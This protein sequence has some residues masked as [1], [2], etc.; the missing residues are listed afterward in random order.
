M[1]QSQLLRPAGALIA[2]AWIAASAVAQGPVYRE[3]WGYLHLEHRRLELLAEL[4]GA[5]AAAQ[6]HAAALLVQPDDGV[7]FT[8]VTKALAAVR[9]VEAD[10]A[11][12]LRAA[13]GVYL[14]P[15]VCDP[16][17]RTEACRD[18]N[19]TVFLP[20]MVP[21]P[22][23]MVFELQAVDAGGKVVFRQRLDRE[24]AVADL[25]MARPTAKVPG[26]ELADGAYEL[27]VRALF[28]GAAPRP[29][30]P[31]LRWTF[32][33]LRGYQARAEAALSAA[34]AATGLGAADA[35]LLLGLAEPVQRAY[36]G[37]PFVVRS[38]AVD[39]LRQLE[40]ALA[41]RADGKP[42]T[43][44]LAAE[45]PLA[46]AD[47]SELPLPCRLRRGGPGPRPLVV[48]VSGT[49]TYD[50]T[51]RRPTAPAVRDPGWLAHELDAF[52]R[53][54]GWHIAWVGS[55]GAGRNFGQALLQVL[56]LLQGMVDTG[57]RAPVLVVE[58]EAATIVGL[59]CREL[60]GAVEAM[61][62]VGGSGVPGPG[63]DALG[64]V[65]M[66]LVRL[67]GVPGGDGLQRSVDY[68][69]QRTG[70]AA[71][72]PDVAWLIDGELPWLLGLPLAADGLTRFVR[73]LSTR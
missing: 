51:A 15:E 25:R 21:A 24:T 73:G 62:L 11:F 16:D 39:E 55:P 35:A 60:V 66:R 34:G 32:H 41:N 29:G 7:P 71:A 43:D 13:L 58:R 69:R 22:G 57:G 48:F 9:G 10:A 17:G 68:A 20:F 40:R 42:L 33:V 53:A 23:A 56:P 49:P 8:P 12:A 47:G 46:L 5:D 36:F 3:Q 63:L 6:Q 26:H 19:A 18:V 72:A 31:V 50:F 38:R 1:G 2:A 37:N 64:K 27:E 67:H 45:L 30:D 44:G 70:A 65:P 28:D 59:R 61:V 54:E 52:G 14:L 4:R